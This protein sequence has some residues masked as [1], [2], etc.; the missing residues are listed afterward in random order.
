MLV[1]ASVASCWVVE[2]STAAAVPLSV[3]A[4]R[5]SERA[6]RRRAV[7]AF[8]EGGSGRSTSSVMPQSVLCATSAYGSRAAI[9][10]P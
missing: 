4:R 2:S 8:A 9:A 7:I 10:V 1:Q 5:D 3:S 6:S